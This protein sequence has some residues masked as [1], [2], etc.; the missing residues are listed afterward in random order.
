MIRRAK[1]LCAL[2][3]GVEWGIKLISEDEKKRWTEAHVKMFFGPW[4]ILF[5]IPY[6]HHEPTTHSADNGTER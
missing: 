2:G 5:D 3:I 6:N 4:I 1:R